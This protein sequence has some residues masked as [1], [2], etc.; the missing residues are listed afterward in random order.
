MEPLQQ[1]RDL[2][3]LADDEAWLCERLVTIFRPAFSP[4]EAVEY[5]VAAN[6]LATGRQP[7][8]DQRLAIGHLALILGDVFD[9]HDLHDATL[10]RLVRK[11]LCHDRRTWEPAPYAPLT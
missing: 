4:H 1:P 5:Q 8:L 7:S 10:E 9:Q 6:A 11:L 2:V 3:H